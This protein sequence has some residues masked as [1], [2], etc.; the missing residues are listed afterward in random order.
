VGTLLLLRREPGT[1][2]PPELRE[3]DAVRRGGGGVRCPRCGWQ[4]GRNDRWMCT[5][6]HVWNTFETRGVCPGCDRTWRETQCLRC[7]QWSP[8]EA[9][10]VEEPSPPS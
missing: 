8:H 7:H 5:C 9:W 2:V 1:L 3:D 6:L 4:P 10:Y